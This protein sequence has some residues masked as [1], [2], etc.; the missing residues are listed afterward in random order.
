MFDGIATPEINIAAGD[1]SWNGPVTL[2]AITNGPWVG[3]MFH[4]APMASNN[5]GLLDLLIAGPVSRLRICALLPRL[6]R[7]QHIGQAEITHASVRKL[8]VEASAPVPSHLDGEV[9][10]PATHFEIE[11]LPRS[12]EL[13]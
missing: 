6:M 5:D 12:L 4:I 11:V 2:A 8:S 13:I 9:Q 10:A 3:G 7:G 1:L